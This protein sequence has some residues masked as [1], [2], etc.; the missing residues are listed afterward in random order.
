MNEVNFEAKPDNIEIEAVTT[1]YEPVIVPPEVTETTDIIES[2]AEEKV[3]VTL[4]DSD[5]SSIQNEIIDTDAEDNIAQNLCDSPIADKVIEDETLQTEL[6]TQHE[7]ERILNEEQLRVAL[8]ESNNV[9]LAEIGKIKSSICDVDARISTLR[10]LADMHE[11]I[12]NN[13]NTQI[14][15][16]KDNLYR[17]IVNPILVEFF[18]IQEDMNL[19]AFGANDETKNLLLDYVKAISKVFKHYGVEVETVSVG[20]KYDPR[21]HKPVKTV[22]TDD[23]S[24]DKTIAKTRKTLV[25]SIDGKIV[26]R[27]CVNVYQYREPILGALME[28]TEKTVNQG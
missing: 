13:L 26:E 14:N 2:T 3:P 21:I 28:E 4:N 19:D 24:L 9:V 12:E 1:E 16:Y 18:D 8:V 7:A 22:P 20:D 25:H 10:K 15:E 23:I 5:L 11:E 27:A 6:E 17:R